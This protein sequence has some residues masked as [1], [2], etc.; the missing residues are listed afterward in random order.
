MHAD[1]LHAP[2]PC[3]L[4]AHAAEYGIDPTKVALW[5]E[6][7]GGDLAV[8]TALTAGRPEFEL[9]DNLDQ[10][11]AV[12]AVVDKFGPSD[13]SRTG[14]ARFRQP[15]IL[16]RRYARPEWTAPATSS[17]VPVTET[18][19]RRRICARRRP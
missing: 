2:R 3:R 11:R 8:M 13:M 10:S 16:R 6:S 14:V 5:G 7:A 15:P 19:G 1:T 18:S 4:R 17:T 12:T 9:G